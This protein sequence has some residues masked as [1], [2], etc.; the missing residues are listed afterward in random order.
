M[1]YTNGLDNP[2]LYFQ[3]KLYA[4]NNST[5]SITLDGS[6][7][8]QPDFVWIKAR[9]DAGEHTLYDSVR[10]ATKRL[11]IAGTGAESTVSNGLTSFDSD[12]FS[13]G[14]GGNENSA[15]SIVSWNWK[16]ATSFS[17]D[18]SATSVGTID[19]SG[20][21]STASGLS[22]I[23]YT[24]TGSAGTIAHGLGTTPSMV[25]IFA[26]AGG[27]AHVFH[28]VLGSTQYLL[29]ASSLA[30]QTYAPVGIGS[31]TSTTFSVG[32]VNGV[33]GSGNDYV[34]YVFAERK[35][36]SSI[37]SFT[38]NGNNDGVFIYTGFK[39][40]FVY[41]KKFSGAENHFLH[42]NK[43]QGYNPEN[44]L[45]FADLTNAEGTVNRIDLL[46]NGF[47]ART[48]D[49][50]INGSGDTYIYMAFAESPFV[51]STGIPTTAR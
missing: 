33:N 26:R 41:Y 1:S 17:N 16:C 27:N 32:T 5:Q 11:P 47:K 20:K 15:S 23:S 37:N 10:G 46:S 35:G 9:S 2:E 43:R 3:T 48:S 34:A 45:L 40:A 36:F 28:K 42:D 12:G 24:G 7:N 4:G 14:A 21:I 51:T 30:V 18:A 19:S 49:G 8:M 39:P 44:E 13:L 38:G 31:L 25:W 6:E 29:H 22:I 50:G